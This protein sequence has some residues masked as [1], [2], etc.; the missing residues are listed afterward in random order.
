[1]VKSFIED[2]HQKCYSCD[3]EIILSM[4]IDIN[5]RNNLLSQITKYNNKESNDIILS[6]LKSLGVSS[7]DLKIIEYK[8]NSLILLHNKYHSNDDKKNNNN[9]LDENNIKEKDTIED[10]KQQEDFKNNINNFRDNNLPI[11][12]FDLSYIKN[13]NILNNNLSDSKK[14]QGFHSYMKPK[15]RTHLE[16]LTESKNIKKINDDKNNVVNLNISNNNYYY[17]NNKIFNVS[18]EEKEDYDFSKNKS[19]KKY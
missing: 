6:K 17:I 10:D 16:A 4:T 14:F 8:M 19:Y 18:S 11:N 1:V 2:D 7:E 15:K 12:I 13:K 9:D 3:K 5:K